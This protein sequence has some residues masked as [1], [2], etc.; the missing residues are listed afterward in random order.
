MTSP[1]P[2]RSRFLLSVQLTVLA[3]SALALA[4]P[5]ANGKMLLL[6]L[7]SGAARTMIATAVDRQARLVGPGPLA[8]SFVVSG[9]RDALAGPMLR[10]GVLVFAAPPAGCGEAAA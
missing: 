8:G 10:N 9:R 1:A 5:P 6:P 2:R 7:G 4:A 3:G